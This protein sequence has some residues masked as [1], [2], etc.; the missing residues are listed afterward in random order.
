M[1]FA[2]GVPQGSTLLPLSYCIATVGL[3]RAIKAACPNALVKQFADDLTLQISD[4]KPGAVAEKQPGLDALRVFRGSELRHIEP[5]VFTT[6]PEVE[7]NDQVHGSVDPVERSEAQS[8]RPRSGRS[9]NLL[10]VETQQ[11]C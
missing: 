2:L 7:T 8:Y 11:P 3:P 6:D 10:S 9:N 4:I 1:K 5:N